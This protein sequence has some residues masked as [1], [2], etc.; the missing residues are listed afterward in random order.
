MFRIT[1]IIRRN[2]MPLEPLERLLDERQVS[3]LIGRA[4]PTLQK[5]R[6]RGTGIRYLKLGRLV[7]YRPVDVDQWLSERIRRSTSDVSSPARDG[8]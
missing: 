7:R 5:D 4:I 1:K 2:S 3:Q 8:A 6:I